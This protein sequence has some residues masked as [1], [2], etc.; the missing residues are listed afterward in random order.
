LKFVAESTAKVEGLRLLARDNE[1]NELYVF[2]LDDGPYQAVLD[3][4]YNSPC[5][6]SSAIRFLVNAAPIIHEASGEIECAVPEDVGEL[7]WHYYRLSDNR[8]WWQSACFLRH[9]REIVTEITPSD[10]KGIQIIG[11]Q[12]ILRFPDLSE[13]LAAEINAFVEETWR[14]KSAQW[15]DRFVLLREMCGVER[16]VPDGT[17]EVIGPDVIQGEIVQHGAFDEIC[18]TNTK[19]DRGW[20]VYR[21][22]ARWIGMVWLA[23]DL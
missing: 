23:V 8:L 11:Y 4:D 1:A 7:S 20:H 14:T 16:P 18:V 21:H 12:G 15:Q 2:A 9:P 6:V 10:W 3:V 19:R 17:A 13:E 5:E 22:R